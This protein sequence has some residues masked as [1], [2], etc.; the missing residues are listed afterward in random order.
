MKYWIVV[1]TFAVSAS[2][3]AQPI[4]TITETG[5]TSSVLSVA[6]SADGTQLVSGSNDNTIRLWDVATGQEF[7]R[8]IGHVSAVNSVVFSPDG[9]QLASGSNDWSLRLWDV[10]TG[11]QVRR[12]EGHP[13]PVN[14][15]VFSPDGTQLASGSDDHTVRLWDVATEEEL[16]RFDRHVFDVHSVVFSPDGTWLA[17]GSDDDT[18]RLWDIASGREIDL[19][20]HGY[21]VYS[22]AI[23]GNGRFIASA[24]GRAI[25]LWDA[26]ATTLETV[27]LSTLEIPTTFTHY[28]NPAGAFTTVEYALLKVSPVQISVHDILGREIISVLNATQAPGSHSLRLATGH[29]SGGMYFLRLVTDGTQV[30]RPLIVR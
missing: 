23:S 18:I 4:W 27:P 30:T 25:R 17:S 21:P 19:L 9:T 20:D 16:R 3:A 5:H 6:F 2:A 26:T 14:S 8:F 15:V 1:L 12:F 22:I 10:A 28:P 29:L 11:Q 13:G 7:L 24:G